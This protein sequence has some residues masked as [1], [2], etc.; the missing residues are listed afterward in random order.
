M[1]FS[2]RSRAQHTLLNRIF[3]LNLSFIVQESREQFRRG[4]FNWEPVVE[5]Q[6]RI[7]DFEKGGEFL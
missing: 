2:S 6:A 3:C 4:G 5:I 7:Q 1:A